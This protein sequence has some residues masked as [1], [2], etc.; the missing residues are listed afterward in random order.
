MSTTH[1]NEKMEKVNYFF[2]NVEKFEAYCSQQVN[3]TYERQAETIEHYVTELR[4]KASTCN[5]GALADSTI[6]NQLVFWC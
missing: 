2:S 3:E 6:R 5:F 1:F 4:I